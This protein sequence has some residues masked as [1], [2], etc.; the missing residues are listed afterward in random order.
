ML[1]GNGPNSDEIP[2][3]FELCDAQ[4]IKTNSLKRKVNESEKQQ[5]T[6]FNDVK[7]KEIYDG[8]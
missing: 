2:N 8:V 6:G 1:P 4:A 5:F 7:G 3:I